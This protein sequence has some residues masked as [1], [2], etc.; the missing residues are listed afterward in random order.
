MAPRQVELEQG[1][2]VRQSRRDERA[3]VNSVPS[4]D[5]AEITYALRIWFESDVA[6]R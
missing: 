4:E 3:I 2:A 6:A 1:I 5:G